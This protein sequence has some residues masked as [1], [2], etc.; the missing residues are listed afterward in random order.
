MPKVLG[1]G[2]LFF[3]SADPDAMK[4]WY[5]RVFDIAYDE[6]GI[7]FTPDAAAAHPGAATVFSPFGTQTEYFAPSDKE[8]MFNLMVD[9]LEGVLARCA[10]H[11]VLPIKTMPDEGMGPFAHIMDPEGRKIELWQPKPMA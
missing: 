2:G 9:D 6:W 7:V 1:L 5:G 4:A 11:G 8:F 10:E 3:K